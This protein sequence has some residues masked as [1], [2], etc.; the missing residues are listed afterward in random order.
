M[1]S[2]FTI[3]FLDRTR[4]YIAYE[5]ATPRSGDLWTETLSHVAFCAVRTLANLEREGQIEV[6][7]QWDAWLKNGFA[8]FPV[9]EERSPGAMIPCGRFVSAYDGNTGSY[10]RSTYGFGLNAWGL[11]YYGP[12]AT[13]V[14][15]HHIAKQWERPEDLL[16]PVQS[17]CEYAL[18][19]PIDEIGHVELAGGYVSAARAIV[20]RRSAGE[21]RAKAPPLGETARDQSAG[22]RRRWLPES[23]WVRWKGP[24]VAGLALSLG[25][26]LIWYLNAPKLSELVPAGQ[27]QTATPSPA[28]PSLS[29]P[30]MQTRETHKVVEERPPEPLLANKKREETAREQARVAEL[31][32]QEEEVARQAEAARR[33][34]E[35]ERIAALRREAEEQRREAELTRKRA[36]EERKAEEQRLAALAL[37]LKRREE[38][39]QA[40]LKE[41]ERRLG[42]LRKRH[43]AEREQ[44]RV[45]EL[46][47]Q[48][49]E[50]A[51]QAEAARRKAEEERI[52]ALRR[53]AE[54]R[55]REAELARRRAEEERRAE[56]QRLAEAKRQQEE[57]ERQRLAEVKR[58]EE[59]RLQ[60]PSPPPA[61]E[62]VVTGRDGAAMVLVPTG[63]FLMGSDT[64]G[65]SP[66][67]RV[68]LEAFYIDQYEVT[69]TQYLRFVQATRHRLPQHDIDPRYDVWEGATISS[70]VADK[71]VVNVDWHDAA[72]YCTWAGKRLPTEA[73]WEKAAR[74]TDAR[75]YPWGNEPP[76]PARL[77]F[78]RRWE[79]PATLQPVGSFESGGSPYG[80]QD[81]AGNVWEWVSDWYDAGYYRTAQERNPRGPASGSAKVL[82]GGAWTSHADSVRVT[83]RHADDPEMR[84]SNVGFR[85]ARDTSP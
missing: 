18:R 67:R 15:L 75:A 2:T 8:E 33:K 25:L 57:K 53:E 3:D 32:R 12:M 51:R 61:L 24:A 40:R 10:T 64:P 69:N 80:A 70:G 6:A 72:A 52:A 1:P 4:A 44:A 13:A 77:N 39:E 29:K 27:V 48:E 36:E 38:A 20:R 5:A 14:M 78:A 34:A 26:G 17:L 62:R 66:P 65:E 60:R 21:S 56:E 68:F 42:E 43:E 23:L 9:Q 11:D 59:A 73:E 28:K 41:E 31:R 45:A 46:R 85:C 76:S 79:G 50:A 82:R 55:Q 37:E 58:Q 19:S 16:R 84:N 63:E 35:E 54:E 22:D 81:M 49:E 30:A 71:P 74:G 7:R 83:H 47:R